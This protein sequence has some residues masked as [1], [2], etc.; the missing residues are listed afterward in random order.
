MEITIKD[1]LKGTTV[2]NMQTVGIMQVIPLLSDI[3]FD[4]FVS[5]EEN[6]EFSNNNYG[7]MQFKNN[8]TE[9]MIIPAHVAY[10]TSQEAQDHGLPHAGLVKGKGSTSY[11]TAACV[12]ESQGGYVRGG[13]HKFTIM[14]FS[15][16]EIALSKRSEHSY[17]K[18][19]PAIRSFNQTLGLRGHG[20]LEYFF[21]QFDQELEQFVAEFETV[22]KQV[23]AIIIINGKVAG[24]ERAPNYKYWKQLWKELVRGCYASYALQVSKNKEVNEK[25][26][27]KIRSAMN[28][29]NINS[30]DDLTTELN[31]TEK[32]QKNKVNNIL[33]GFIND[34][35]TVSNDEKLSNIQRQ[36]VKNNQ[37][38]GQLVKDSEAIVYASII[39]TSNWFKNEKWHTA[40]DFSL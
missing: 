13:N 26:I 10:L 3:E 31:R 14:P 30:L 37:F 7:N 6:C 34:K 5:P 39:T 1:I 19:W 24:V 17:N 15:I 32:T 21:K 23:G 22:H 28:L 2:G 11:N 38:A 25:D 29:N 12:Q 27:N 16:R 33:K 18:L 35:F 40:G 8:N 9:T 20:H 36:N 4:G